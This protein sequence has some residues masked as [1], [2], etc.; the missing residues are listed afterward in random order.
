[1]G[2][3]ERARSRRPTYAPSV[4]VVALAG[5]VLL[6]TACGPDSA[7]RTDP[8][9]P[10]TATSGPTAGEVPPTTRVGTATTGI[11]PATTAAPAETVPPPAVLDVAARV[12][13]GGELE[14]AAF[15]GQPL[16]LWFW[17]PT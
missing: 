9:P 16:A 13:G 4:R 3:P 12:V 10:A 8:A 1:M 5:V 15:A 6:L 2:P 17:A 7:E 11:E 14:L